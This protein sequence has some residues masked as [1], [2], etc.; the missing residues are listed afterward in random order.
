MLG[1]GLRSIWY[2]L[3]FECV[4]RFAEVVAGVNMRGN[5]RHPI[6]AEKS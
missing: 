6:V 1:A 5:D 3:F 4:L 2:C